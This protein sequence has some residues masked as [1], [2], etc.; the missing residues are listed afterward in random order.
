M[1]NEHIL[2]VKFFIVL[3]RKVPENFR[4]GRSCPAKNFDDTHSFLG[5]VEVKRKPDHDVNRES[6]TSLI[7]ILPHPN[8]GTEGTPLKMAFGSVL[9][10]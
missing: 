4:G 6:G 1:I 7:F 3:L 2:G 5:I 9:G 8:G 10:R